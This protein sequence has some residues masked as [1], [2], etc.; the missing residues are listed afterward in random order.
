LIVDVLHQ[1][2][3]VGELHHGIAAGVVTT[4]DVRAEL[5]QVITGARPGRLSPEEIVVFDS[6]GTAVQD[7]AAA[8]ALYEAAIEQN[9]G[10]PLPLWE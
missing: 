10:R 4:D 7:V 6:T 5:G 2:A 9:A 1:C 8:R 3:E